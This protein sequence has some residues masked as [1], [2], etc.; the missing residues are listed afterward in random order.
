MAL[1]QNGPSGGSSISERRRDQAIKRQ[2]A[3][4]RRGLSSRGSEAQRRLLS[5]TDSVVGRPLAGWRRDVAVWQRNR[6]RTDT[7]DDDDDEDSQ[8]VWFVVAG[9]L[10]DGRPVQDLSCSDSRH[11]RLCR[12][13][14]LAWWAGQF[15][16]FIIHGSKQ[17]SKVPCPANVWSCVVGANAARRQGPLSQV[18]ECWGGMR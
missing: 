5:S 13:G 1:K 3:S 16:S 7:D 2:A 6:S 12:H 10:Q 11:Q 9:R 18:L 15:P 4:E 17:G 8:V 14:L